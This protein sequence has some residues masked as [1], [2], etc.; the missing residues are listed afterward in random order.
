MMANCA[1]FLALMIGCLFVLPTRTRSEPLTL[2]V[3]AIMDPNRIVFTVAGA[4]LALALSR[5]WRPEPCWIDRI[6]RILGICWF[7]ETACA[8]WL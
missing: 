1:V 6:G 5:S 8:F 7:V 4:W 3:M 2:S